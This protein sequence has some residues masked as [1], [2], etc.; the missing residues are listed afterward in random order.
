MFRFFV[1]VVFFYWNE[2]ENAKTTNVTR[3]SN[4][5]QNDVCFSLLGQKLGKYEFL[6]AKVQFFRGRGKHIVT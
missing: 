6:V 5:L 2:I 3:Q 4:S 1:C